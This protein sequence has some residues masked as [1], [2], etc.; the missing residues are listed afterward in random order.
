MEHR[1]NLAGPTS[2]NCF[3]NDI[4]ISTP[5]DDIHFLRVKEVCKELR[6]VEFT[7]KKEKCKFFAQILDLLGLQ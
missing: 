2:F 4:L 7:V 3:P 1:R 6:D 5:D